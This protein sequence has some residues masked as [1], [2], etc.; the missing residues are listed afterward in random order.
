M[1]QKCPLSPL[2]LNIVLEF[3]ARTIGQ[4]EMKG[5]QTGKEEVKLFLFLEDL[6]LYLKDPKNYTSQKT[7]S[8]VAGYKINL[9]KSVA[10]LCINNE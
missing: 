10:F 1:R 9:H 2:L 4:E 3:L 5:I 6:V 8:K 7:F